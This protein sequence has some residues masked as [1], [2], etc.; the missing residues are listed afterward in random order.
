MISYEGWDRDYQQNKQDYEKIFDQVMSQDNHEN[1]ENLEHEFEKVFLGKHAI[2]VAS[3]TDALKFSLLSYN[4][5]PGDEVLVTD[6]S[7][8]S[9]ASC[10]SMVGATPVFCDIDLHSYHISLDSIKRMTTDK[11]KAL[12]Y[13]H[14]FGNMCETKNIEQYCKEH[15]IVFIEDAA[16]NIG[17][18]FKGRLAGTLGDCSSFS[19]NTNKI[20]AGINGGGMFLTNNDEIANNVKKLR[21]HGKNKDFELLGYNS[22]MYL[23]NA[24]I[25]KYRL[26]NMEKYKRIKQNIAK[27]YNY[28]FENLPVHTQSCTNEVDHNFHKYTVRFKDKETRNKVKKN[29]NFSVHYETPLSDNSMYKNINYKRDNCINSYNLSN[30]ILSLPIHPWLYESEIVLIMQTVKDNTF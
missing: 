4:I 30:T 2:S 17:S 13:T 29:L 1:C 27:R 9:S 18:S 10:I 24:E 6:F 12:I 15:N 21:R 8:I 26:R 7:W 16:Q 3:A 14:L 20:V 11:T 28:E 5:G 25:I 19:F 22:K 23:L